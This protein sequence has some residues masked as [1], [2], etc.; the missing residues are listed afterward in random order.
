[1]NVDSLVAKLAARSAPNAAGC[2]P[3]GAS[4]KRKTTTSIASVIAAM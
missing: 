1:M 2:Q 3:R 4:K